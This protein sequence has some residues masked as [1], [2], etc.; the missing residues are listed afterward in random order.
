MFNFLNQHNDIAVGQEDW[1]DPPEPEHEYTTSQ[2]AEQ[3]AL[4]NFLA[5]QL[6]AF[7]AQVRL[8]QVQL[9]VANIN[10]ELPEE[11]KKAMKAQ[12]LQIAELMEA[13]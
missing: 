8:F 4:A 2:L 1:L 7:R 11:F 10:G 5:K 6:E 9:M 12:F 3:E 13:E